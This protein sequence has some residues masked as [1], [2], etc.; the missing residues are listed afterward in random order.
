MGTTFVIARSLLECH[1]YL[2]IMTDNDV[3]SFEVWQKIIHYLLEDRKDCKLLSFIIL[4]MFK[5]K[6]TNCINQDFI[7]LMIQQCK[8]TFFSYFTN[9]TCNN[10]GLETLDILNQESRIYLSRKNNLNTMLYTH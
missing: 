7:R 5:I 1:H 8:S 6:G 4:A 2:S 3:F 9:N 10:S